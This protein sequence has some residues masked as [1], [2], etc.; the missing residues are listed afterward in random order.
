MKTNNRL[1]TF[2]KISLLG[3]AAQSVWAFKFEIPK[4]LESEVEAQKAAEEAA[5]KKEIDAI[6]TE[7]AVEP[8]AVEKAISEDTLESQLSDS[9]TPN[10]TSEF[11]L[12]ADPEDEPT[13]EGV[14]RLAGQ[15]FDKDTGSPVGG[16]AVLIEDTDFVTV[17]DT[18]GSFR[19]DGV[20]AGEY[21]VT[22]VKTGYI[23]ASV[24]GTEIVD[25]ETKKLDFAMPPRPAEMSDEAYELTGFTVTAEE[26][27]S[28]N[29]ALLALRQTSIA[30]IDALSSE[31][32]AKF[33]ASDAADAIK[34]IAG[35]SLNDGKYVVMRGL[36]DRYN[37]TLINGV[38]LPSADPDRKAVA[39]DI[40]P[41]SLFKS[42]IARKTYTT[43]MPGESSG[44][45]IELR[46]KTAPDEPFIKFSLGFGGQYA[47]DETDTFLADPEQVTLREW[48]Q[49][50]DTRGFD[51]EPGT[52]DLVNDY[53]SN[54][55]GV[56]FPKTAPITKKKSKFEDRSYSLSM[57]GS[58]EMNDWLTLG[59]I[60]GMKVDEKQRTGYADVFKIDI[61]EGFAV[62]DESAQAG[63]TRVD[64]NGNTVDHGGV[65]KSVEEYS[66]S[67]LLGLGAQIKDHTDLSYTYLRTETLTSTVEQIDYQT[68]QVEAPTVPG[69]LGL[70]DNEYYSYTDYEIGSEEKLL[71][72]H[73]FSGEH[74]FDFLLPSNWTFSWYY[75]DASTKQS[76]PDQRI[77]AEYLPDQFG[78]EISGFAADPGLPP[79][80]RYQRD[81]EQDSRMMGFS[82]EQEI[83]LTDSIVLGLK[84]GYADESSERDFRQLESRIANDSVVSDLLYAG[85]PYANQLGLSDVVNPD[86][87][88]NPIFLYNEGFVDANLE[89]GVNEI[90]EALYEQSV[91]DVTFAL[92]ETLTVL[93]AREA[94][95]TAA[96]D[97]L[98]LS[99]TALDGAIASFEGFFGIDYETQYDPNVPLQALFVQ[100]FIATPE[101]TVA[102]DQATVDVA[103]ANFDDAQADVDSAQ[104]VFDEISA[105]QAQ[106]LSDA[107]ALINQIASMPALAF[108]SSAFP[109]FS[110]FGD[111]SYILDTPQG[112]SVY[113]DETPNSSN[114]QFNSIDG[115]FQAQ[116]ENEVESFFVSGNLKFNRIPFGESI[117]LAG[118]YRSESTKLSYDLL[119]NAPGE[120]A[121][122]SGDGAGVSPLVVES[123]RIDQRDSLG[124]LAV[125][126]DITNNLKL[127]LS[128]STTVAKPT[129]REIAPFPIF[130]LS[131]KS[132]EQGNAGLMLRD[133]G[134]LVHWQ[135][136]TDDF[137]G[138]TDAEL[139]AKFVV[140][141]EFS[142]LDIAE[143]ENHDIRL[144]YYTPFDGLVSVGYFVKNIGAPI[145]R[146]YAYEVNGVSVNTFINNDN[147]AEL[148]G[149]EF[150]LQQNLAVLGD[151][152]FGVPLDWITVGGNYTL[153]DAEVERSSLEK[154]NFE[155]IR[156]ANALKDPDAY[157]EGG[158][159]STRPLY[160]Q[161]SYVANAF[162][163]LDIK[164]IGTRITLSQNWTGEQLDR[165]G[166]ISESQEGVADLYWADYNSMNLVVEQRLNDRWKLKFSIKNLDSPV[167]EMFEDSDFYDNLIDP[168]LYDSAGGTAISS[169]A[170]NFT[171]SRQQ[172]DPTYSISISGSF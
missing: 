106:Y 145:E 39:M 104:S 133:E 135:N 116:G 126:L 154:Q 27:A 3:L 149:F 72:A 24:T 103:Q 64:S 172:F 31:D 90:V 79:I 161:P 140:P 153:L 170:G 43:D 61:D 167:R 36:N 5:L 22:F 20:S 117:R 6:Q 48:L 80:T 121:S 60:F 147:D 57:G 127:N 169:N 119:E 165:V 28:Q 125:I 9:T 14:G 21:T 46:T 18:Q 168:T 105:E 2:T 130:N 10:I 129:Y 138:K 122:V 171:R 107:N 97:A 150:E 100:S 132:F 59:A 63:S 67:I 141:V 139:P 85:M 29:V 94:T 54:V 15:V 23:E 26:V 33:G 71:E 76:E 37:T 128:R 56:S 11:S 86:D 52:S 17:T 164:P 111:Q 75:T 30:S 89:N 146:V 114:V 110:F 113:A 151:Q 87:P 108:D 12:E 91:G 73:Q 143:V 78:Q 42:L 157:Q 118:G 123:S 92:N 82:L 152:I 45:S 19:L 95:L 41:T 68:F 137:A 13:A 4:E 159:Y 25:G 162:V 144:E 51:I 166:G 101:Q 77:I 112:F 40:F 93:T 34:R 96:E 155:N 35:A 74:R 47:R 49:G 98:A 32:F 38:R 134:Q 66:S 160:N 16:V 8:D 83:E 58:R 136:R 124:Y 53:S 55:A 131:D 50:E 163:S 156:F 120:P 62:L 88:V 158:D 65:I 69:V 148:Q 115:L 142:G 44:G 84:L 70:P 99:Q 81:T 7:E 1:K 109:T 102:D